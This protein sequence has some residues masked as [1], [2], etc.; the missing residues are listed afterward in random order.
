MIVVNHAGS[1]PDRNNFRHK[2]SMHGMA[3]DLFL[4]CNMHDQKG[5]V[6]T[7]TFIS[8]KNKSS[9]LHAYPFRFNL[10]WIGPKNLFQNQYMRR[11]KIEHTTS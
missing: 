9:I 5:M 1:G 8:I 10:R 11:I 6:F 3:Y 2:S 7:I 4:G